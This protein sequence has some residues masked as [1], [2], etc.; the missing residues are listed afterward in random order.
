MDEVIDWLVNYALDHDIGV[1]LD[2]LNFGPNVSASTDGKNVLVNMN[3][4]NS[5]EVPFLLAHEISHVLNKDGAANYCTA[6]S[7]TKM[8]SVAN[9]NAIDLLLEYCNACDKQPQT[10]IDFMKY[11]GIPVYLDEQTKRRCTLYLKK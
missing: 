7:T 1:I 3:W 10:Y 11:Y 2:R 6:T 9:N 8:E 5:N 4:K